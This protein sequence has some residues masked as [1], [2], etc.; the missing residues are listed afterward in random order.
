M[1]NS[2]AQIVDDVIRSRRSV[3]AFLPTPVPKAEI[4]AIKA[5]KK[6]IRND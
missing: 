5:P 2:V 3:R 4:E 1:T 6:E